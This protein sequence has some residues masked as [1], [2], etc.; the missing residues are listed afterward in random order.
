MVM[1]IIDNQSFDV[2]VIP[3]T[4]TGALGVGSVLLST[5]GDLSFPN[6]ASTSSRAVRE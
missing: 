6:W 2:K 5:G 1:S 3:S 4:G